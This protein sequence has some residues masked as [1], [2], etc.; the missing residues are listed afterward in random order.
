MLSLSKLLCVA[1]FQPFLFLNSIALNKY[2]TT[3]LCN[4]VFFSFDLVVL[5]KCSIV[6]K[7]TMNWKNALIFI[8]YTTNN[9]I[10][11]SIYKKLPNILQ[12]TYTLEVSTSDV[13]K[14]MWF[15]VIANLWHFS[16][17]LVDPD[18]KYVLNCILILI[19]K[20]NLHFP[21]DERWWGIIW[22]A[23]QIFIFIFYFF[24][25]LFKIFCA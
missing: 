2:T 4:L 8:R 15:Y 16:V 13:W 21:D 23:I 14:L 7:L 1:I 9:G 22:L 18:W 25:C 24:F 3:Y 12:I 19:Y 6:N 5:S 10:A 17:C 11:V 20:F